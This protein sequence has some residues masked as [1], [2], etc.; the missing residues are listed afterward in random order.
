MTVGT[1]EQLPR[2]LLQAFA[3]LH[4]MAM[5][6]AWGVVLGAL[7]FLMTVTLLLKGGDVVG[8]N[9]ALLGQYFFGYSVTWPGAFVGLLWGFALG[10]VLGWGF[11]VVRNLVFWLWLVSIRSRAEMEQYGDFLDHM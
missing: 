9:L 5:G 11:A 10:F 7:V 3:P 6:L 4:R 8:P 1:Q 2:P